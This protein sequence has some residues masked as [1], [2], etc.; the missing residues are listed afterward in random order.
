MSAAERCALRDYI[1]RTTQIQWE[2]GPSDYRERRINTAPSMPRSASK[3]PADASNGPTHSKGTREIASITKPSKVNE[4]PRV[5][6]SFRDHHCPGL[7]RARTPHKISAT[8][9]SSQPGFRLSNKMCPLRP[10]HATSPPSSTKIISM[11]IRSACCGVS[12]LLRYLCVPLAE[13]SV[14]KLCYC[15]RSMRTFC[16][17]TGVRGRSLASRGDLEI[18]SATSWPSTTSPKMVCLLSSQRVAATAMKNW[19]PFVPGPELAIDSFPGLECFS[20]G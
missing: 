11:V 20:E 3:T 2:V 17:V 7:Y 15:T 6:C 5:H 10:S 14:L 12:I 13:C 19:L 8:L 16:N 1:R 18:L 9:N 4:S